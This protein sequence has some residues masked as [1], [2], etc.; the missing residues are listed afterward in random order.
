M[1]HSR[2]AEHE[3]QKL[4]GQ[5]AVVVLNNWRAA[6]LECNPRDTSTRLEKGT[7]ASGGRSERLTTRA[8]ENPMLLTFTQIASWIGTL[9]GRK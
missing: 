8:V 5:I 9:R 6:V 7:H 4:Q 3:N 1:F 2:L